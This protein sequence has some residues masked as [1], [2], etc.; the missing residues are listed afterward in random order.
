[1]LGQK[2]SVIIPTYNSAEVL[3]RAIDSVLNQSYKNL[4]VIVVDDGSTDNTKDLVQK[5]SKHSNFIYKFQQNKGQGAARNKGV[6]LASGEY[7]AFLDSDDWWEP[8]KISLQV[9]KIN[10]NTNIALVFTNSNYY[11]NY[12]IEKIAYPN[13]WI[14]LPTTQN[15]YNILIKQNIII[16]SSVLIKSEVF[17]IIGGFNTDS[18]YRNTED[19][20][21]WLRIARKLEFTGMEQVLT[22]YTY[23][24]KQDL[25][26]REKIYSAV[27]QILLRELVYPG[28]FDCKKDILL[29]LVRLKQEFGI[30]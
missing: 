18:I 30:K 13:K 4:E 16:Q 21:L 28:K 5:Y 22:N 15:Y 12:N 17:S 11:S 3:E 19:Y 10:S 7:L 9:E 27:K 6:S 8:E 24:K 20:E 14:K 29:R 25:E 2:V 26:Y 23:T 1:M